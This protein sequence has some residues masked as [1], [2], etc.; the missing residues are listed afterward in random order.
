M[1]QSGS[2]QDLIELGP[3]YVIASIDKLNPGDPVEFDGH[4]FSVVRQITRTEARLMN[5][6]RAAALGGYYVSPP[7]Q[8][9]FYE[10]TTD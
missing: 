4:P 9:R 1:T 10:L 2:L 8:Y 3:P 6:A 5:N 7:R